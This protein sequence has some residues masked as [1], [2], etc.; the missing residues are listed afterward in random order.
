MG[1]ELFDL[2]DVPGHGI[3][4]SLSAIG[5]SIILRL[6]RMV[7]V[8][9]DLQHAAPR[10]TSED[11]IF[12]HGTG[13]FKFKLHYQGFAQ[14]NDNTFSLTMRCLGYVIRR[15]FYY[16]PLRVTQGLASIRVQNH[17]RDTDE[18]DAEI[19]EYLSYLIRDLQNVRNIVPGATMAEIRNYIESHIAMKTIA[20]RLAYKLNVS[21]K[22]CYLPDG[23]SEADSFMGRLTVKWWDDMPYPLDQVHGFSD[24]DEELRFSLPSFCSNSRNFISHPELHGVCMLYNFNY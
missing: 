23:F 9:F 14:L 24:L 15:T 10:F 22:F 6:L 1:D 2:C 4:V 20:G 3:G 21:L 19:P 11:V 5:I 13:S 12:D 17:G 7:Y 8:L 16:N 18:L